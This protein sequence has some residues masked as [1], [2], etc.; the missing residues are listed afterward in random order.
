[1][2]TEVRCG[3]TWANIICF[4]KQNRW[5][6]H[7]TRSN[8]V[9][10]KNEY[11]FHVY[12]YSLKTYPI[13]RFQCFNIFFVLTCEKGNENWFKNKKENASHFENF[14]FEIFLSS[15]VLFMNFHSVALTLT[16]FKCLDDF[17]SNKGYSIVFIVQSSNNKTF[18]TEV[19]NFLTRHQIIIHSS[20]EKVVFEK[21]R[22]VILH[23]IVTRFWG[24]IHYFDIMSS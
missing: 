17:I 11:W 7:R 15:A 3:L 5:F 8:M 2:I 16:A 13:N 12:L 9:V 14:Q 21:L 20:K 23:N 24:W 19:I 4:S 22:N 18:D 1:M 6:S 10:F